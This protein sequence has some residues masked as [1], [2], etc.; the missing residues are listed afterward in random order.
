MRHYEVTIILDPSLGDEGL[1]KQRDRWKKQ[2]EEG[3]GKILNEDPW[4]VRSL[5][6][7]INKKDQ[8]YYVVLEF[9]L[10]GEQVEELDNLLRLDENVLRHLIIYLDPATLAAREEQK[11]PRSSESEEQGRGRR[12]GGDDEDDEGDEDDEDDGDDEEDEVEDDEKE[13]EED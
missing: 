5:A 11:E 4:G 6:Y 8:G 10:S 3:G 13:E 2:I 7:P 9:E 12:G 1:S